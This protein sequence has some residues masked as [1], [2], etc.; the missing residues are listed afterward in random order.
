[1]FDIIKLIT[2]LIEIGLRITLFSTGHSFN[3]EYQ[4]RQYNELFYENRECNFKYSSEKFLPTFIN[5]GE[6]YESI[7]N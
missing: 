4:T 3:P 7:K 6:T 2:I 1:M 5:K